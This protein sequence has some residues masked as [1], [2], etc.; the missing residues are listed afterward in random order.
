[1][2]NV[3][4]SIYNFNSDLGKNITKILNA[5]FSS[6]YDKRV[7]PNYGGKRLKIRYINRNHFDLHAIISNT[8]QVWKCQ[9]EP[10]LNVSSA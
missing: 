8:V 4:I 6:G 9:K 5:F 2:F 7:R 10:S 1:M 3:Y